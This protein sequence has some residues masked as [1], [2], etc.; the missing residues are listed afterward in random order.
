MAQER[1]AQ[2]K[3]HGVEIVIVAKL[4]SSQ[5]GS[6]RQ[7]TSYHYFKLSNPITFGGAA[8]TCSTRPVAPSDA[9]AISRW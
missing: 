9:E 2:L 6:G 4:T 5:G 3:Q 7:T 1:F 8:S